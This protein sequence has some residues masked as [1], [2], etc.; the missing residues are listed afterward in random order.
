MIQAMLGFNALLELVGSFQMKGSQTEWVAFE[1]LSTALMPLAQQ[2]LLGICSAFL[3]IILCQEGGLN[4]DQWKLLKE[5]Q[6]E[7]YPKNCFSRR[8]SRVVLRKREMKCKFLFGFGCG[9]GKKRSNIHSLD[10][11]QI[12]TCLPDELFLMTV[13]YEML[14][15]F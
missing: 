10:E 14:G 6:E 3:L 11:T 8:I 5:E 2:F 12:C 15:P 4:W 13:W 7:R 1:I 9:M